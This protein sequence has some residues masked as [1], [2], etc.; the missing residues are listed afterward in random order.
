MSGDPYEAGPFRQVCDMERHLSDIEDLA[1]A[2]MFIAETIE[3][4]DRTSTTVMGLA[5]MIDEKVKD[6]EVLRGELFRLT[7]PRRDHFEREG[8]P[9]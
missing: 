9:V 8:W 6:V 1:C 3:T 2:L 7:H 4:E 5:M